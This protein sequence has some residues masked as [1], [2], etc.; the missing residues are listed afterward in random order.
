M[1]GAPKRQ[2]NAEDML[3][4]LKRAV[5]SSAP[6]PDAPPP[7]ASTAPKS[8]SPDRESRRSQIDTGSDRPA[9]ANGKVRPQTDLR[10]ST[11]PKSRSWKPIAGGL[12][13]A[14]AAT[15]GVIAF[16]NAAPY[17]PE[18]A[19]SV[20]AT[21]TPVRS[22]NERTLE[23][24]SAP[25]APMGD[26]PQ[27]PPL[28]ADTA[29]TPPAAPAFAPPPLNQ[30]ATL[31]VTH[32]IRPDGTPIATAPPG[33]ASPDSTPPLAEAPKTAAPSAASKAIRPDGAPLATAPPGPA[34][35][36]SA[37]P[38]AEAPK[39]AA[40]SAASKAIG[41]DGPPI[42]TALPSPAS[43]DSAPLTETS[44]PAAAPAPPQMIKP[45]GASVA[46]APSAPVSIDTAHPAETPTPNATPT[47][48]VSNESTEPSTPKIDLKK[49][50]LV[51][52]AQQKLVGS[53]K[54]PVRPGAQAERRSTEPAPPKEAEKSPQPTQNTGSPTALAPVKTTSVQQRVAD[55]VTHAFGY[56]VH[57][58][59]ALVPHLGGGPNPDAN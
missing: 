24:A 19:P 14:G 52:T 50:P 45:D 37:P 1:Q 12:V 47:A 38:M 6:A 7:S 25:R 20:A 42:A 8:N 40:P 15:I 56:L 5:E 33:P 23:P 35:P 53:P 21:E 31:V 26:S 41:A 59:G 17:L 30:G 39:T 3:A 29:E 51:R 2:V 10:K 34:S 9:T 11:T 57:L 44:K 46:T 13:L 43:T 4:E 22:Q 16:M 27:A 48:H 28:Q 55:G 36:D 49:K 54:P 32:R 18:R 58:P